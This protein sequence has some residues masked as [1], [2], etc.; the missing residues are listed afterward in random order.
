LI[1]DQFV[2]RGGKVDPIIGTKT[3]SDPIEIL[4]IGNILSSVIRDDLPQGKE[5]NAE[6][7]G[8]LREYLVDI[9]H[10]R[11]VGVAARDRIAAPDPLKPALDKPAQDRVRP[12]DVFIP[13]GIA[14]KTQVFSGISLLDVETI[15]GAEHDYGNIGFFLRQKLPDRQYPLRLAVNQRCPGMRS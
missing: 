5:A 15:I 13:P 6:S 11:R 4:P 2:T 12:P 10:V 8:P 3:P 9:A 14:S 7:V 1:G